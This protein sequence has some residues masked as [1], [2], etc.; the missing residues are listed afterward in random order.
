MGA[1]ASC[2]KGENAVAPTAGKAT[3]ITAA[4]QIATVADKPLSDNKP[5]ITVEITATLDKNLGSMVDQ[6]IRKK[7]SSSCATYA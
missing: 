6:E 7:L 5:P 2:V 4:V 1:V 3:P